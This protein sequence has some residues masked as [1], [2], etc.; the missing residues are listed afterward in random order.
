VLIASQN[1][2]GVDAETMRMWLYQGFRRAQRK[3]EGCRVENG[4]L[5]GLLDF[6]SGIG[7]PHREY[8]K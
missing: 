3:G 1:F 2:R 8:R 7:V 6:I 5:M 4:A